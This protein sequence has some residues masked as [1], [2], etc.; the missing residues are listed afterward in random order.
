[1]PVAKLPGASFDCR[2]VADDAAYRR[3]PPVAGS[4]D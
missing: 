2:H 4:I 1:V 3:R